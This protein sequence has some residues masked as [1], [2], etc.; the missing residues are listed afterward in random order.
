MC[1]F[2]FC[3]SCLVLEDPSALLCFQSSQHLNNDRKALMLMVQTGRNMAEMLNA[4]CAH[5]NRTSCS[6]LGPWPRKRATKEPVSA[7]R[8]Q[9][10]GPYARHQRRRTSTN[11]PCV[12]SQITGTLSFIFF[13]SVVFGSEV[14]S[15]FSGPAQLVL[16]NGHKLRKIIPE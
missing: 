3:L 15:A 2:F 12:G 13:V 7:R 11:P 16:G 5:Q 1:L 8:K 6:R 10:L 4:R 14:S 9:M